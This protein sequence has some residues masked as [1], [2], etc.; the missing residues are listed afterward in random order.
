[1]SVGENMNKDQPKLEKLDYKPTIAELEKAIGSGNELDILP[2]GQV[3]KRT[4]LTEQ[5]SNHCDCPKRPKIHTIECVSKPEQPN[6]NAM[7]FE[8]VTGSIKV[9][10]ELLE[11]LETKDTN[12]ES[13]KHGCIWTLKGWWDNNL[14]H[15]QRAIK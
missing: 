3:R 5:P 8:Q 11:Q 10:L 7:I 6:T 12:E 13:Q 1:M 2:N 15:L 14:K 4:N 9:A